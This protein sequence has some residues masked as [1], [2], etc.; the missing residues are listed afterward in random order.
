MICVAT[1]TLQMTWDIGPDHVQVF[2]KHKCFGNISQLESRPQASNTLAHD[3]ALN[4]I[5]FFLNQF[6]S[7][8]PCKI[9][10]FSRVAGTCPLKDK[11]WRRT[12]CA[13]K[14]FNEIF[15][16][17]L[18]IISATPVVALAIGVFP[19]LFTTS[20]WAPVSTKIIKIFERKFKSN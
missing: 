15:C 5:I 3:P 11:P 12:A 4:N 9:I 6:R 1:I 20:T 7:K 14:H 8:G 19:F 2:W 17:L 18:R 13:D 10:N 16:W